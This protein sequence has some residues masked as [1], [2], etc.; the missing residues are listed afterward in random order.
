MN[1]GLKRALGF[2]CCIYLVTGS[3]LPGQEK[4]AVQPE[5]VVDVR[6]LSDVQVSA[7]GKR[8]AFVVTERADPAKPQKTGDT[9]IWVAPAD[10]SE[11]ARLFAASPQS[12]THPRWSPDGR[13]LAF[14][15]T[16]GEPSGDEKEA[17]N[18]IYLLHTEGGEAGQLTRVKGDVQDLRWSRDGR[19]I[20]FTVLDAESEAEQKRHKEGFDEHFADHDYKFTRLWVVTVADGKAE[21][22]THQDL[23]VS[24]FDWSPDGTELVARV[25]STTR[26]DDVIWHARLVIVR[27]LDGEIVR[28]LS[29]KAD[30]EVRW[31]PDGGT[32]AFEE[33]SPAGIA[34][35]LVV[36]PATGG[37]ARPLLQDF[38][39]TVRSFQW[40]SD[41]KHLVAQT[42]V[43]THDKF[44]RVNSADGSFTEFPVE[45][46]GP[47]PNF[48]ISSDGGTLA[49]ARG[50]GDSPPEVWAYA[51]GGTPR[52][53][54][55]LN[56]QTKEWRLGQVKEISWKSK[57]DGLTIYGVLVTP[58]DFQ[59]GRPY[60]TV[61]QIHGG[62]ASFW[63]CG[64]MST[65]NVWAQMLAS[66]GYVV[67]MPDPRGSLGQGWKFMEANRD[68]WGGGD[69]RD[70]MDGVDE[71]VAQKIADPHRL[72]VGGGSYGG[73]MTSWVVTQTN[74]FKAAVV[75]AAVTNLFSFDGN[76]DITP[77]FLRIYFLD[78]PFNRRADYDQHSAM[79][80]LKNCQ[81]PSLVLH[82]E[83]DERVPTEQGWEFYNGLRMLG[84]PVELVTYPRE[85]HGFH[86]RPHQIDSLQRILEW[87]DKYL[88]Q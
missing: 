45:T 31:S 13:T 53:L 62:P 56:P 27:R 76:T 7:D 32:I 71:L 82:G 68:D 33:R 39:G 81:T 6:A 69:F 21:Q 4:R 18:Q 11:P 60:P 84:V 1:P 43:H 63:W 47:N 9:N 24:G 85:H 67:F 23:Q 22:V 36:V 12:D 20:A 66:H 8:V 52:K 5:D 41:S 35:W 54:T 17:K 49:Y 30:A 57:K 14:L 73:Y 86:E 38:E 83:A 42:S 87:Y 26:I 51:A 46:A 80:F 78:L 15:S 70:I 37:A 72:G 29:E 59:P 61:V 48:S 34:S 79:T 16:R 10:G 28:T 3:P 2:A 77:T 40:E 19:M 44:L 74:R 75:A 88:K 55:D 50:T 25:S 64:W 65:P 58:P